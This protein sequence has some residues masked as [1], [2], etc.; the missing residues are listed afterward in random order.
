MAEILIVLLSIFTYKTLGSSSYGLFFIKHRFKLTRII[1]A[2][3]FV[4]FFWP[5]YFIT[6]LAIS[7]Y[8][9]V[10]M[11]ITE[12]LYTPYALGILFGGGVVAIALPLYWSARL[13]KPIEFI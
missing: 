1:F 12:L 9:P 10:Y 11:V 3:A 8:H 2:Y 13:N 6:A 5:G 4:Y 7:G